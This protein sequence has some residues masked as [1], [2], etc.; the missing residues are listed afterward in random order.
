VLA[1]VLLPRT[2]RAGNWALLAAALLFLFSLNCRV[3][4]GVRLVLPLLALAVVGLAAA[5]ARILADGGTVWRPVIAGCLAVGLTW[6]ALTAARVWPDGLRYANE[7]WGGPETAYLCLSDSNY[8]WGQ[9]LNELRGWTR[10]RG[11]AELDVWYFGTEQGADRSPLRNL[12]LHLSDGGDPF[13]RVRGPYLAASTTMVYGSTR[14]NTTHAEAAAR[15]RALRPAAR[16]ST[17]LIYD[18]ADLAPPGP[19]VSR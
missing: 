10:D 2:R 3:Q 17:Y 19:T 11:L 9:G 12:P 13:A 5:A 6:N 16:T 1:L 18:A 14:W 8:D 4:I 15:L 7:L